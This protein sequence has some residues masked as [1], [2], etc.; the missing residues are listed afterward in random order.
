MI[1]IL[2]LGLYLKNINIMR[3]LLFIL[4]IATWAV[5]CTGKKNKNQS[6]TSE[7][8]KAKEMVTYKYKI[9]GLQDSIISDSIW[10][11]IFQVDGVDKL[12][13]SKSDSSA[14]FTVDPTL[15]DNQLL[16][17]EIAKRGGVV[18]D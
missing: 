9:N 11:I 10:R 17:T 6:D 12:I 13:L 4:L 18:L 1:E 14:I 16:K 2:C 3:K 5:A 15:V 8:E 7:S